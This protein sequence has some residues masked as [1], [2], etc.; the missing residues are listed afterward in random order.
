MAVGGEAELASLTDVSL[1]DQSLKQRQ[2]RTRPTR[3]GCRSASLQAGVA[4]EAEARLLEGANRREEGVV[5]AEAVGP[6]SVATKGSDLESL[7]ALPQ[8]EA[9]GVWAER[10]RQGIEPRRR[11]QGL[12]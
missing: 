8:G 3:V 11:G 5:V 7:R 1:R 2:A 9:G 4:D 10:P 12:R 6:D